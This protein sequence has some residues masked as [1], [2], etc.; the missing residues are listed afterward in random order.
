MF[1]LQNLHSSA[2]LEIRIEHNGASVI[3]NISKL[4]NTRRK[5]VDERTQFLLLNEFLNHKGPAFKAELMKVYEEVESILTD[6]I[7]QTG[8]LKLPY[9]MVNIILDKFSLGEVEKFLESSHLFKTLTS[10]PDEFDKEIEKDYRF[11][12]VQT[13]TKNDYLRLAALATLLKTILGPIGQYGLMHTDNI[14]ETY[15]TYVLFNMIRKHPI[16]KSSAMEKLE[17]SINILLTKEENT[18]EGDIRVIEKSLPKDELPIWVL[19]SSLFQRVIMSGVVGDTNEDNTITRFY[20]FVTNK[21]RNTKDTS[22]AIRPK[23]DV[24]G[25]DEG[26]EETVVEMYRVV[27]DVTEGIVVEA[28]SR[29][30]FLYNNPQILDPDIDLAIFSDARRFASR[31]DFDA[32]ADYKTAIF[33]MIFKDEVDPRLLNYIVYE[34]FMLLF[35]LAFAYLW[36]KG[37]KYLALL[38]MSKNM[39]DEDVVTLNFTSN[40]AKLTPELK[41][42][43][44]KLY[45]FMKPSVAK[46]GVRYN[47]VAELAINKISDDI[48]KHSCRFLADGNYIQE[49]TGTRGAIQNP[50]ATIRVLLANFIIQ[51]QGGKHQH[52]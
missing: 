15:T 23:R 20:N 21:M 45:P 6:T 50:P 52:V 37:H 1:K 22:K 25:R 39:D 16:Y 47:N 32:F 36:S 17:G 27:T 18:E 34:P 35:P 29:I 31:L 3:F 19:A 4:V 8:N 49:A 42:E 24:G 44:D 51:R 2:P 10:L 7:G 41:V 5:D 13:Y 12:R 38:I 40:R 33:G 26:G 43:L 46:Q 11:T 28:T 9:K 30:E 14:N 48:S